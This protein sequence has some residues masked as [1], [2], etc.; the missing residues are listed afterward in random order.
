ME[1]PRAHALNVE[2]KTSSLGMCLQVLAINKS[3]DLGVALIVKAT[4]PAI[5]RR[6]MLA[7]RTRCIQIAY[8]P[9]KCNGP[10]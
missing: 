6:R 7:L 4:E 5:M 10:R 2:E 8:Q 9:G 3:R 1:C